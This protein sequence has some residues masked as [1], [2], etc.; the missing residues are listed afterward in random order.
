[1]NLTKSSLLLYAVTDRTWLGDERLCDQV[2]K[3]LRGG[4]SFL[5]LREKDL[6]QK[7][8]LKDAWALKRLCKTYKVPFVINDHV[9][10]ARVLDAD[11]VHVGQGDMEAGQLRTL[12]GASKIIGVSVQT[13]GQ[14]LRAESSGADYLGVGAIFATATKTDSSEVS[15]ETLKSICEAVSIPVVAIGGISAAR[16]PALRGSGISGVAVVSSLFAQEDIEGSASALYQ[17]CKEVF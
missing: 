15:T 1:M 6:A 16:I 12:L 7:T 5:Q 13:V 2:E 8:L 14:A 17:V 10:L 9:E 4:V 3:S 11:G